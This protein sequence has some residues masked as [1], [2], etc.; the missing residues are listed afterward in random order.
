MALAG[1]VTLVKRCRIWYNLSV[2]AI[3][4]G[5]G[6]VRIFGMK[7]E[8]CACSS[9]GLVREN[10]EDSFTLMHRACLAPADNLEQSAK[11]RSGAHLQWYA[12][13]DGMGGEDLGEA[14]S[15]AA[16][17]ALAKKGASL[18]FGNPAEAADALSQQLNAAVRGVLGE[19]T[20]GA[21]LALAFVR[22]RDLYPCH[23]GDSR[24][25][26]LRGGALTR[27]TRDH[28]PGGGA[29]GGRRSHTLLRYLGCT[30]DASGLCETGAAVRLMKGDQV[31]LCS[32]GV[33]DMLE[34]G[35]ILRLMNTNDSPEAVA[36]RLLKAALDAGGGDNA[37]LIVLR[38][39]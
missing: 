25:Y 8:S 22:G 33:T 32:D 26:H 34:D 30:E 5:K 19:L 10:N 2:I 36:Q 18:G 4:G 21:T 23:I 31:L 24:I 3:P 37:T 1:R 20:G 15:F 14:A 29:E 9:A 12:V 7:I 38:C 11:Y 13:M 28:V 27:L 16:A 6:V 17:Q 39:M 35:A